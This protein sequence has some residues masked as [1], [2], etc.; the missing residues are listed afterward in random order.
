MPRTI[1]DIDSA[2]RAHPTTRILPT[3]EQL[4]EQRPTGTT[5]SATPGSGSRPRKDAAQP[6]A[7]AA[8][9]ERAGPP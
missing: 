1:A 2:N 9:V 3:E 8:L 5:P 7:V 6:P 4:A